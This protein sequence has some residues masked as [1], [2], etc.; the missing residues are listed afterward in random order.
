MCWNSTWP[1]MPWLLLIY[2]AL[3]F[4]QYQGIISLEECHEIVRASAK[5]GAPCMLLENVCYGRRELAV[6]NMVRKG[7]FGE[8]LHGECG[9]CHDLRGVKFSKDGEGLWR[10]AHA[11]KRNG[12]FYPTHGLGPVA[13]YMKAVSAVGTC[14]E[15]MTH[16]RPVSSNHIARFHP[17]IGMTCKEAPIFFGVYT[18]LIVLGAVIILLP[19]ESLIKAMLSSQTLNGVL[20]PVILIV[21]LKLINDKRLMGRFVN[22]RVFNII[23]WVMV[24][25]LILLD[26]RVTF[27]A[28]AFQAAVEAGKAL[29]PGRGIPE[30]SAGR[31]AAQMIY[32]QAVKQATAMGFNDTFFLLSVL[33][34][35]V[36]P[37][38]L[39]L[40]RPAHQ[41]GEPPPPA[42]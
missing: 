39:F 40:R 3:F 9:Y 8:V 20:L 4:V 32:G 30:A 19:I 27:R 31:G 28:R 24:V 12:N 18:T 11:T 41:E 1:W 13:W 26:L 5:T 14:G 38:V 2:L 16:G 29:L 25:V 33:M 37:L 34:A 42:H 21:M 35:C 22:G 10:R 15:V 6:L 7:L 36:L 17:S 23:S